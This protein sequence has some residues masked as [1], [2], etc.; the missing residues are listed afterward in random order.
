MAPALSLCGLDTNLFPDTAE[1]DLL[2][3]GDLAGDFSL[4][5]IDL[6][7]SIFTVGI[8]DKVCMR[9]GS[10]SFLITLGIEEC[11]TTPG[12]ASRSIFD[13]GTC[14]SVKNSLI[15]FNNKS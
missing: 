6:G 12:V 10:I 2:S 9:E 14:L 7:E 8:L 5:S 13:S 1:R 11:F 15:F 3:S 4:P